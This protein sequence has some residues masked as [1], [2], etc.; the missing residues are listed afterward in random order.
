MD[1]LDRRAA[2]QPLR[3]ARAALRRK[4]ARPFRRALYGEFRGPVSALVFRGFEPF[5][6]AFRPRFR[7]ISPAKWAMDIDAFSCGTAC[8]AASQRIFQ[9]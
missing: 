6:G 4:A 8:A 1:S 3:V 5:G 2:D 7:L 9:P